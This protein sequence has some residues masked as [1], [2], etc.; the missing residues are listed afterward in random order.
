MQVDKIMADPHFKVTR[1]NEDLKFAD[2]NRL[3]PGDWVNDLVINAFGGML[4]ARANG[5]LDTSEY[6]NAASQ[7]VGRKIHYFNSFF[8]NKLVKGY[9]GVRRWSKKVRFGPIQCRVS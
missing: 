4:Q 7:G 5:T 9:D 2:I 8:Y 6:K 1:C 3:K